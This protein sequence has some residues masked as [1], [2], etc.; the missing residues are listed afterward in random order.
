MKSTQQENTTRINW[1]TSFRVETMNSLSII[2]VSNLVKRMHKESGEL[3]YLRDDNFLLSIVDKLQ[4]M[5][6]LDLDA[7]LHELV[8]DLLNSH[9]AEQSMKLSGEIMPAEIDI[10]IQQLILHSKV[11]NHAKIAQSDSL[12]INEKKNSQSGKTVLV[13]DDDADILPLMAEIL[14]T[15]GF[16]TLTALNGNE[17]LNL[18][19]KG[20]NPDLL[21][22]DI[23]MPSI[24][25]FQLAREIKEI[26]PEIG[27][28]YMSG[29]GMYASD[30]CMKNVEVKAKLLQK[31]FNTQ[32][33]SEA[34]IAALHDA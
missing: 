29:N 34:L 13:V 24:D 26:K 25:G 27:V 23:E 10:L 28:V 16:Q 30:T 18:V 3:V 11:I 12:T 8:A 15:L 33:L 1:L 14:S 31:P 5:R 9:E 21:L 20:G 17:A 7:L 6:S 2:K 4:K 22:T 19:S 32:I